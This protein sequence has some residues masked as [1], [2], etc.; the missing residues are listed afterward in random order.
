MLCKRVA[1]DSLT[2]TLI[3]SAMKSRGTC[4]SDLHERRWLDRYATTEKTCFDCR[5]QNAKPEFEVATDSAVTPN[6]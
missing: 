5:R 2:A 4:A 1:P 6:R 3:L